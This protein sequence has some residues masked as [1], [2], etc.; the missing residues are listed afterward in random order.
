MFFKKSDV[1]APTRLEVGFSLD[2]NKT[3]TFALEW[4]L[5]SSRKT[6]RYT[7]EFSIDK[8]TFHAVPSE[9]CAF[10]GK[11]VDISFS[12]FVRHLTEKKIDITKHRHLYWRLTAEFHDTEGK[13]FGRS[14]SNVAVFEMPE[15][16]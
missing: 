6:I 4:K 15:L 3:H 11:R 14:R 1:P 13:S 16:G 12:E 8:R 7:V 9:L 2:G 10:R 5:D